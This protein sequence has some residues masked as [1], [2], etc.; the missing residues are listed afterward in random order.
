[1]LGS[2]DFVESVLKELDASGSRKASKPEVI[3]E[4]AR[5]TGLRKD[6]IFKHNRT[7][8]TVQAKA[9]YCY[10][11]REKGGA[12]GVVL[13]KELGLSS[14]AISHLCQKGQELF[15]GY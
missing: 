5:V 4:V 9:I 6:L 11:L 14:G 10:L 8:D 12:K 2:G 15:E 7:P 13:A 3:A 1:M